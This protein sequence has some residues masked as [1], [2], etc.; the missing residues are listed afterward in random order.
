MGDTF[1]QNVMIERRT[2]IETIGELRSVGRKERKKIVGEENAEEV[3]V[4][5]LGKFRSPRIQNHQSVHNSVDVSVL[6][7]EVFH[8]G[9]KEVKSRKHY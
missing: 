7:Y 8:A 5:L 1:Q 4:K 3:G 9:V 6:R 2:G